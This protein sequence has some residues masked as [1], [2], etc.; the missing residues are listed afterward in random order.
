MINIMSVIILIVWYI[1][2]LY[3]C[4]GYWYYEDEY[5]DDLFHDDIIINRYG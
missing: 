1:L 4:C 2:D 5:N 3:G